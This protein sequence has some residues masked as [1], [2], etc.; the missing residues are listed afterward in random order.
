MKPT[1]SIKLSQLNLCAS[2]NEISQLNSISR[3]FISPCKSLLE[4]NVFKSY[5]M[6]AMLRNIRNLRIINQHIVSITYEDERISIT[7]KEQLILHKMCIT[8][9]LCGPW[10]DFWPFNE[11]YCKRFSLSLH[12]ER[13]PW[14][15]QE[16]GRL[17]KR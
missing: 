12:I 7:K 11:L 9:L 8:F 15:T 13:K 16:V 4:S 14:T 3:C 17:L 1:L 5:V 2:I 10:A 6:L